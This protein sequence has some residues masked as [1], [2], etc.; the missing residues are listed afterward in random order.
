MESF[1][2]GLLK[3]RMTVF[4]SFALVFAMG[5]AALSKLPIDAFPD[6]AN[7]QVQV[8]TEAPGMAPL[9][10]EQLVTIPLE[11][12]MNGIPRV[13]QIR[14]ISKYGLSVVTVVF[15]DNVDTY[16]AR[17]LVFEKL[18]SARS[19]LPIKLSPQLGPVSTAMGEIYQY[20]VDGKAYSLTDLKTLHDFDVKYMLRTVPGVAEVNT[21]GGFTDE[22]IV[23][24]DPRRLQQFNLTIKDVFEALD[25]NNDN[26]GAGIIDHESEQ[27]IV[28]GLGRVN[29]ISDIEDIVIRTDRAVPIS[30]KNVATVGHGTALR[31]GAATKDGSGETVV[32][33][34][35]M[36]KGENSRNVI[37]AVKQ[38]ISE[39]SK[40]LPEGVSL[41]PFYDQSRLVDQVIDTVKTNLLEGGALVALVLLL[42]VGSLRASI[43]VALA[44]PFSMLFSFIGMQYLGV[45]ANIMSLGAIDFGMIVDGS[46]V[47]I[48]NILRNL[49]EDAGQ[50][51]QIQVIQRSVKEVARPILFGILIITVVYMPILCLEGME[52]KM[53]SPMV[54]TVCSALL[55][56]L[57]I[58]LILVPALASVFLRGK[59]QERESFLLSILRRP[60]SFSLE[61]ALRHRFLTVLAA[62]VALLAAL[63]SAPYLGTEFVPKLDE[64][65]I[66]IEVRDFPSISLPASI[67][68]AERVERVIKQV[69]E[70][71]TVVSRLGRPDLATDPMG[72]YQNDCFVIL[73]PKAEW[74]PGLTK[75][76]LTQELRQKLE[77]D[78]IGSQ[79]NFTQ[80][81][82]MRVDELVSGV[83]SDVAIKLFGDD[84]N[85]LQ[86][87]AQ[88]IQK[89]IAT[90]PG[91][92]DLQV[93][94]LSGAAQIVIIPDREKL[95]RYGASIADLQTIAQTAIIG[96]PVSEVLQGR[97][98]FDLRVKFP[99]GSKMEPADLGNLLI[100]IAD[101]KRVPLSQ[102]AK[103]EI[104]PGIETLNREFAQRRIVVQC[105]VQ[106]RDIGSFVE[107]CQKKLAKSV[108]LKPGYYI[109]WGGQ[110]ENQQRATRKL[111]LAVPLSVMIIFL[112]LTATFSSVKNALIVLLNVP[113][114]LIGGIAAL[115]IRG[116]YLS[117]PA[118]IGFIALFGVAVLNGL[119]LISYINR[120]LE[121]GYD[122]ADAVRVGAQKRLRPVLMTALVASLGFL[123][124][125][126]SEGSGAEVQR[127][128]ATVVIG[129][130]IS[131]TLLTLI[132]LPVIFFWVQSRSGKK[133]QANSAATASA[134]TE[135]E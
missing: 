72:V 124:M 134:K 78:S 111:M 69:P 29:S 30:I 54:V 22:Y 4:L 37:E 8:L 115:W 98:R 21:W 42:T 47:M 83:R 125:A 103:I 23:T 62:V 84:I 104:S 68:N 65:D 58:S 41:Q 66:L 7:N 44:I 119:V 61:L 131:S 87:Q 106:N 5:F 63:A 99:E 16:F 20:R 129:G 6:L 94:R 122:L 32:G 31:Q 12:I 126:L 71:K 96:T 81:I 33:L 89:I 95:A 1:F 101:G 86:E 97:K 82:A 35:M 73:K 2:A 27:Y 74:R 117:V 3:Q 52:L 18:Q 49:S 40:S 24:V 127:P 48:E 17:Q 108:N 114:A 67:E 25:R 15:Q 118:S 110:F 85:Y 19:R 133:E 123:P 64:G 113:F 109:S 120:L 14:S 105:N 135:N 46:I 51:P 79:F 107:E 59:I 132:V 102:L 88:E 34:V 70:V 28:R 60:Y 45:S 13:T 77:K 93:E 56:S 57:L 39:I 100:E 75:E 130:L 92:R 112:L 10:V 90:V 11:S 121:S 43:I 55:G 76:G 36:L 9:E 50:S 53:F 91:V 26:F 128:L 38:K 116:M 80:P